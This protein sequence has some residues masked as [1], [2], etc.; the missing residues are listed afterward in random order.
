MREIPTLIDVP[1]EVV[2][3]WKNGTV[4][5]ETVIAEDSKHYIF[6]YNDF[7]DKNHEAPKEWCAKKE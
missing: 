3:E 6:L 1:F 7:D 5:I 2:V 4:T